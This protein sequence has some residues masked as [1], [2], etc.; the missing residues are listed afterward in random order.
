MALVRYAPQARQGSVRAV[1]WRKDK[2]CTTSN[3]SERR[4]T[5]HVPHLAHLPPLHR[6]AQARHGDYG[7]RESQAS[8][9]APARGECEKQMDG[10]I[11]PLFLLCD[12]VTFVTLVDPAG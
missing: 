6:R 1:S 10:Q 4:Q 12:L 2:Q 5:T 11:H 7:A 9:L 8:S 3:P